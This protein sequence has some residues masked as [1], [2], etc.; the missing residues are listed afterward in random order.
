MKEGLSTQGFNLSWHLHSSE[1]NIVIIEYFLYA[2][3]DMWKKK[4]T[5]PAYASCFKSIY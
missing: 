5:E 1:P 2:K 4:I 3:K